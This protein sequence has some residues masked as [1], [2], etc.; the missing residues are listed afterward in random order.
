MQKKLL[1]VATATLLIATACVKQKFDTD[2]VNLDVN[3][4]VELRFFTEKLL[5]LFFQFSHAFVKSYL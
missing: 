4:L 1:L 5:Q 2:G 3:A